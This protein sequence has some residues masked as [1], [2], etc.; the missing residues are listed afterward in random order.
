V[1]RLHTAGDAE[2]AVAAWRECMHAIVDLKDLDQMAA[3]GIRREGCVW[4]T[5]N[6]SIW[7]SGHM[8]TE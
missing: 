4:M 7:P 6:I 3:M 1:E 2:E 5:E 8:K